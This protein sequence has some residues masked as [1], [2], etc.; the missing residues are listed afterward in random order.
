MLNGIHV[1][2]YLFKLRMIMRFLSKTIL[3]SSSLL[4]W[5]GSEAVLATDFGDTVLPLS[6]DQSFDAE[7]FIDV[8][9]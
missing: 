8:S 4:L 5:L 6:K 2:R 9:I 3:S 1:L 7:T